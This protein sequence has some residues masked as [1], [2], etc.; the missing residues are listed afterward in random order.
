MGA[1]VWSVHP[2]E[3]WIQGWKNP[4]T[5]V[6]A[7]P[8]AIMPSCIPHPFGIVILKQGWGHG[9][10]ELVAGVQPPPS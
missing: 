9:G 8:A 6:L 1:T 4:P 3:L 10:G 2:L 7:S 5:S